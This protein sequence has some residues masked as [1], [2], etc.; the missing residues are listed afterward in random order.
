MLFVRWVVVTLCLSG[1]FRADGLETSAEC[2]LLICK[3]IS[4]QRKLGATIDLL[5]FEKD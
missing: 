5:L 4:K 1:Y 2:Y 3:T